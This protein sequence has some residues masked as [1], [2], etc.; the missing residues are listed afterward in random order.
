MI[1]ELAV[2][3]LAKE[4]YQKNLKVVTT[5][6]KIGMELSNKKNISLYNIGG[7]IRKGY[8]SIG[9][10]FIYFFLNLFSVKIN[11]NGCRYG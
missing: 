11:H 6:L 3:F 9:G 1:Q 10:F 8:Y 7:E 5:D 4:L 2:I